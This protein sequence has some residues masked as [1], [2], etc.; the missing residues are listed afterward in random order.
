MGNDKITHMALG[1]NPLEEKKRKK[2]K[3]VEITELTLSLNQGKC[4][5]CSYSQVCCR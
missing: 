3:K 1:H 2:K 5:A 4:D